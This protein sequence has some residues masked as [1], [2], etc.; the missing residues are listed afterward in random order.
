MGP[1]G[2]QINMDAAAECLSETSQ[3]DEVLILFELCHESHMMFVT[4]NSAVSDVHWALTQ[5]YMRFDFDY[6]KLTNTMVEF[7]TQFRLDQ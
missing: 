4:G 7:L 5:N 2:G 6:N 3:T 1:D